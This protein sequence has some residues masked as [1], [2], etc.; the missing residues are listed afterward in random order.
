MKM[1]ENVNLNANNISLSA[2]PPKTNNALKKGFTLAET[3]MT[4]MILGV[5]AS[6]TI[7]SLKRSSDR[8]ELEAGF[9]KGY[10]AIAQGIMRME[11]DGQPIAPKYYGFNQFFPV[12]SKYFNVVKMYG[13]YTT[14]VNLASKIAKEYRTPNNKTVGTSL[15]DDGQF[16][17]TDGMMFLFEN[18]NVGTLYISFDTNGIERKPN[19]WGQDLFTFQLMK[20]G[21]ILPM[22]A[23]GTDYT[24]DTYC[25]ETSGNSINGV[26]CAYK[27]LTDK[28]YWKNI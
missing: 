28:D 17:T 25:S 9:K 10:S 6:M 13:A 12:Y 8:K 14:E 22:G 3:L 19:V 15:L 23:E 21:D 2:P 24:G 5:V 27:A 26:A 7:P 20:N 11:A 16:I 18:C 1:F 4:L